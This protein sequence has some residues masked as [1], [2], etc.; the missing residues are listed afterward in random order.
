MATKFESGKNACYSKNNI[1]YS[2]LALF[3]QTEMAEPFKTDMAD[4]ILFVQS[5]NVFHIIVLIE[6]VTVIDQK[7]R[8]DHI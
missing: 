1:L 5:A 8:R 7:K 2:F 4:S 6:S 3:N